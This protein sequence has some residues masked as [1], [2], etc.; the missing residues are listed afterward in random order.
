MGWGDF[1]DKLTSGWSKVSNFITGGGQERERA[2]R[3]VR[4]ANEEKYEAEERLEQKRESLR[5]ALEDLGEL[6]QAVFEGSCQDFIKIWEL[7]RSQE[8]NEAPDVLD[9]TGKPVFKL[10]STPE[11]E[12]SLKSLAIRTGGAGAVG[13][14]ALAYG[15]YGLVGALGTASSGTAISALGGVAASNA[16]LAFLGGGSLSA[17]GLGVAGGMAA[18]GGIALIP[19]AIAAMYFGQNAAKEKL[20]EAREYS[21]DVDIFV[22]DCNTFITQL[23][24]VE[25]AAGL[26]ASVVSALDKL[27]AGYTQ[28]LALD[29]KTTLDSFNTLDNL[30]K[31]PLITIKAGQVVSNLG[32]IAANAKLVVNSSTPA[33]AA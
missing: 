3:I 26:L 9:E 16:T 11:L 27:L 19:V 20:N 15:A 31:T 18:L 5:K 33:E 2:D 13:G 28:Q 24:Q 1:K 14:V 22:A 4:N 32:A 6:R 23:D 21:Y 30:L 29:V 17:G 25:K 10:P 8:G 7:F 12:I